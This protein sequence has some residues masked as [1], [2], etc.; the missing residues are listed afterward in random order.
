MRF[1][2]ADSLSSPWG[3][4]R[5]LWQAS[6]RRSQSSPT[7][8]DALNNR[9]LVLVALGRPE[10]ALASFDRALAIQ[11]N[12]VE[13]L[14][15]VGVILSSLKRP[16]RALASFDKAL[17]IK[18]DYVEAWLNRGNTLFRLQSQ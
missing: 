13:A 14:N 7:Y 12:Y 9:A 3:G 4:P 11:P 16:E 10:D 2:I 8:V 5:A 1:S 6:T 15:N 17:K 18:P